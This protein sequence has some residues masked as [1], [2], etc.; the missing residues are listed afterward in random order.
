MEHV[1][2]QPL[3]ASKAPGKDSG[4]G[5][6]DTFIFRFSGDLSGLSQ[7]SLKQMVRQALSSYSNSAR[8][9]IARDGRRAL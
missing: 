2:V 7:S 8:K 5:V 4:G 9:R 3:T 1:K 6:G